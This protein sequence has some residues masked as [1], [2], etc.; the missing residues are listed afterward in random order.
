M[1]RVLEIVLALPLPSGGVTAGRRRGTARAVRD[2]GAELV[3]AWRICPPV[4]MKRGH[5][6]I[7]ITPL[8]LAEALPHASRWRAWRETGQ[9]GERWVAVHSTPFA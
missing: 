8:A 7:A 1:T 2:F 5:E 4:R 9:A 3:R 6:S